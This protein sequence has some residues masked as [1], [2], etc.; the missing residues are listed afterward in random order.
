M[1][2]VAKRIYVQRANYWKVYGREPN[3]VILGLETFDDLRDETYYLSHAVLGKE[4]MKIFGM[5][6]ETVTKDEYL[7]VGFIEKEVKPDETV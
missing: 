4:P 6:I 5:E 1:D 3:I 7:A 2:E